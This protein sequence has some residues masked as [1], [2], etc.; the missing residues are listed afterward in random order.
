MKAL[1]DNNCG[2]GE[3]VRDACMDVRLCECTVSPAQ[4]NYFYH[5]KEFSP[6]EK[7]IAIWRNFRM[8]EHGAQL[9]VPRRRELAKSTSRSRAICLVDTS[10]GFE[11]V[12]DTCINVY[13][14]GVLFGVRV[15]TANR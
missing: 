2:Q 3:V 15:F 5:M 10:N 13:S 7:I 8:R 6:H 12:L 1:C 11:S 4:K 14:C 9:T